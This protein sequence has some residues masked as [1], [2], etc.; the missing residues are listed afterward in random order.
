[1]YLSIIIPI[2]NEERKIIQDI[3][4]ASDFLL[5]QNWEG[6]IIVVDDGSS[7]GTVAGL[8]KFQNEYSFKL[9]QHSAN[10]GKGGA[11]KT[12]MLASQGDYVMF[13]D[14]GYCVPFQCAIQGLDLL[15]ANQCD[16]A[17]GSRK[18]P[19][20]IV[21]NP[22]NFYRRAFSKIFNL[23]IVYLLKVPPGFTDTQC[24]FKIFKGPVA[25]ELFSLCETRG[26]TFDIEILLRAL[27]KGYRV[28][29]FPI[30]WNRDSDSRVRPLRMGAVIL[31]E[32]MKTKKLLAT[33]G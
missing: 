15:T 16:L 24:G 20:S 9:L 4:T 32:L 25:R 22:P 29:E 33:L 2:Y 6:E 31:K 10:Q 27:K 5:S 30:T 21:P 11:V 17:F 7:D 26:F 23:F 12:G 13:V 3:K 28:R 14:S 1:M 19:A 8:K 18:L